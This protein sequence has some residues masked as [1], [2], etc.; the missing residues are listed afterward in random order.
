MAQDEFG[1]DFGDEAPG[2]QTGEAQKGSHSHAGK[3]PSGKSG[4]QSKQPAK[5]PSP[6]VVWVA[7]CFMVPLLGFAIFMAVRQEGKPEGQ[8]AAFAAEIDQLLR[9]HQRRTPPP[10][11]P[12]RFAEIDVDQ[13]ALCSSHHTL[14]EDMATP[15]EAD[16][17]CKCTQSAKP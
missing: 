6:V 14:W 7:A 15:A 5:Q 9:A 16:Y 4:H 17:I 2:H 12:G 3:P 10:G 13:K 8:E 11:K 1:D